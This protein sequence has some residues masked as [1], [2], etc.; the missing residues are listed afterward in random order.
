MDDVAAGH[1][2]ARPIGVAVIGFGWMGRVHSQAYARVRHHFPELPLVPVLVAVADE[3]PAAPSTR[4]RSSG[5]R[6]PC[7]TG[8][9]CSPT[10]ASRR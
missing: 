2:S 9:S 5:S 7:R 6:R 10:P 8:G 1:G 4:Q 3:V